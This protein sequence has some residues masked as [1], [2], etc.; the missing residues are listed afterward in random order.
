MLIGVLVV[1]GFLIVLGFLGSLISTDDATVT[2]QYARRINAF[3]EKH[4]MT[5]EEVIR[6][7]YVL[8]KRGLTLADFDQALTK[9]AQSRDRAL[10]YHIEPQRKNLNSRRLVAGDMS[11]P[12]NP[13]LTQ[14][15]E[16]AVKLLKLA[17][18]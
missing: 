10:G 9:L 6:W 7:D 18:Y 11:F 14:D 15:E 1:A 16:N 5:V 12:Q 8:S 13:T 4:D 3:A 2:E 17:G